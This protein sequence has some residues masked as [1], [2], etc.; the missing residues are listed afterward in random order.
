MKTFTM[1]GALLLMLGPLGSSGARAADDSKMNQGA[2]QVESEPS[3]TVCKVPVDLDPP[4]KVTGLSA[5]EEGGAI[6]LRWEP[7]G[8]ED[9][10]GYLVLRREVGS[11]TLQKLTLEPLTRTSYTDSS[12]MSGRMYIYVVQAVD[13]RIPLPNV[14]DP[15]ETPIITAR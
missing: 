9:L 13:K 10:G 14:S 5:T 12:V 7:N 1:I 8:E 15:E 3:E 4:A 6:T 11:D 2:Q